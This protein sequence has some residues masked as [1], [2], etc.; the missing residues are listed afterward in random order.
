MTVDEQLQ[1]INDADCYVEGNVSSGY[2]R[3]LN[4]WNRSRLTH[5]IRS[6]QRVVFEWERRDGETMTIHVS[7]LK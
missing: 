3:H 5:Q 4:E 1:A 7:D 6:G 2:R